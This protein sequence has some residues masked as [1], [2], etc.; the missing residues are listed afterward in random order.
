MVHIFSSQVAI[1]SSGP[2]FQSSQPYG[3]G[4]RIRE[5]L[6]PPI[7]GSSQAGNEQ[8]TTA[9][10]HCQWITDPVTVITARGSG[11]FKRSSSSA[12]H[13]TPAIAIVAE[14][15]AS[16]GMVMCKDLY[17]VY[18]NGSLRHGAST[19]YSGLP[20]VILRRNS[21]SHSQ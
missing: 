19:T 11:R 2:D 10:D 20:K 21:Y 3:R 12:G 4:E 13:S 1:G 17:D 15:D 7:D 9:S 16:H 14:I 18:K 6:E 8:A 5:K